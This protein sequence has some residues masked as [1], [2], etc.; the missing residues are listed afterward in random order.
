MNKIYQISGYNQKKFGFTLLELLIVVLVAGILAA[1][2]LPIY[3]VAVE[4]ARFS[5]LISLATAIDKQRQLFALSGADMPTFERIDFSVP[6]CEVGGTYLKDLIC[7]DKKIICHIDLGYVSC[8]RNEEIGYVL[9]GKGNSSYE[10]QGYTKQC[11]A[12]GAF[13]GKVCRSLGGK[14]QGSGSL[15]Y[16]IY[17]LAGHK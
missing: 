3:Q 8:I 16:D 6:G 1:V 14:I 15:G 9:L 2:A 4:K 5:E 17:D 10:V 12:K 7:S 13:F 11:Y